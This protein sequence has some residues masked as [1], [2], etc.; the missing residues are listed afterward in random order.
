[1]AVRL[2]NKPTL[3]NSR[4]AKPTSTCE[5]LTLS[6]KDAHER[7]KASARLLIIGIMA[8]RTGQYQDCW[9]QVQRLD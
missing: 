6:T 9:G 5:R 7:K 8:R 2:A 1:M 3:T 4:E